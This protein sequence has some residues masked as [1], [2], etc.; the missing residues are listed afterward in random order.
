[1][2]ALLPSSCTP[3]SFPFPGS[4]S[5]LAA[6]GGECS[7]QTTQ[8]RL[9]VGGWLLRSISCLWFTTASCSELQHLTPIKFFP[10]R[11]GRCH[12]GLTSF[13][14]LETQAFQQLKKTGSQVSRHLASPTPSEDLD[15]RQNSE[16]PLGQILEGRGVQLHLSPPRQRTSLSFLPVYAL[17]GNSHPFFIWGALFLSRDWGVSEGKGELHANSTGNKTK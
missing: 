9:A 7:E 10:P 15:C 3:I 12:E 16:T 2:Q 5:L 6:P 1:M 8:R 4:S 14:G 11:G 13:A 17:G